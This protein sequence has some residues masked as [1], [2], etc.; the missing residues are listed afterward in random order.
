MLLLSY[1]SIQELTFEDI[2]ENHDNKPQ[3][4]ATQNKKIKTRKAVRAQISARTLITPHP[5]NII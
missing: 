4:N 1:F 5:H 3:I 2:T